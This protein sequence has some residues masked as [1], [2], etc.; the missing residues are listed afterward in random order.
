MR[1]SFVVMRRQPLRR[2]LAQGWHQ[3]PKV[4]VFIG[5]FLQFYT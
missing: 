3:R 2:A 5:L 4:L 1:L